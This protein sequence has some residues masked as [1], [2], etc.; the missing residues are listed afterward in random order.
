MKI[1]SIDASTKS[2]GVAVFD[3]TELIYYDCIKSASTDLIKR[4]YIMVD[5]IERI[6]SKYNIE[7]IIME[8]VLP[9]KNPSDKT[10]KAL[11]YLQAAINFMLY[12]THRNVT[13]EYTYPSSWRSC[14]GIRTGKGIERQELKQADIKFANE[15]Y[16]LNL[17][18]KEDDTADAICIGHAFV[19]PEDGEYNWE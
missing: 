2:S 6:I 13:I 5:G 7:K 4:I 9:E 14:C 10:R 12:K 18:E 11:M 3:N 1:L 19:H 15:T 17:S 8:E 16:Q